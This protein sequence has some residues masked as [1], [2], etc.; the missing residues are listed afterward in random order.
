MKKK[1]NKLQNL[2]NKRYSIF[3]KDFSKCYYCN[4]SME[5]LDIH[6]V[7]GGSNRQRS[8]KYGLC[9][10]LCR[11]CHSNEMIIQDLRKWCQRKYEQTHTR[12]DFISIIGRNY[13]D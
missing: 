7:Y 2:E 8:M 3:T 6:E 12:A 11:K 5:K 1:S 4:N 10:P 13:L 9:V